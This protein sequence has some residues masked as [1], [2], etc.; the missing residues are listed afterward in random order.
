MKP[1][2]LKTKQW[3]MM[4]N[5]ANSSLQKWRVLGEFKVGFVLAKS[6]FNQKFEAFLVRHFCKLQALTC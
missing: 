5:S 3:S 2:N 4:N 6:V 1:V